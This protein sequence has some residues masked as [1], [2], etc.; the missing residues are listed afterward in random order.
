M[1]KKDITL[2]FFDINKFPPEEGMLVFPI[3]MSRIDNISQSA[4]TYWKYIDNINPK[5]IDKTSP[6]SKVGAI[7]VYGDFLYLHSNEKAA[8]LKNRFMNLVNHHKNAF[9][10]LMRGHPHV[11]HSAFSY[12]VW[13]QFYVD[14]PKYIDYY[15]KLKKLYK[16]DERFKAHV[17]EDFENLNSSKFMLDENQVNFFIEEH[18][19][20]YLISKGQMK[21][22]NEFINGHE[23]W[24]LIAYPGKPLKAHIYLHQLNPFRLKNKK[25]KYQDCWYDLEGKKLYDF[26]KI[27]LDNYTPK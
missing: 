20:L 1:G 27:D 4:K 10:N 2:Q 5:K 22:E 8:V 16:T 17:K 18:L 13:N 12:K 14:E 19:M 9:Q 24:I 23:N 3:S 26:S 21:L 11:I 25:N 6:K 7:F 15:E